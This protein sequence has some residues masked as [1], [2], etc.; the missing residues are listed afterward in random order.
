[1]VFKKVY[2]EPTRNDNIMDCFIK[3]IFESAGKDFSSDKLVHLQFQKFSRG[4]FKD[5]AIIIYSKSKDKYTISTTYEYANE[6]V[7]AVAEKLGNKKILVSG[8]VVSTMDLG[9]E[10]EFKNIKQYMGVKQYIFEKELSGNE[11][12]ELCNKFP[13]IFLGFSFKL[14]DE[15]TEIKIKPKAPKSAKP[16]VKYSEEQK[17]KANF[18]KLTT[19]DKN[20]VRSFVFDNEIDI[21]KVK[22]AEISHDFI[23]SEII[24]PKG[25]T[26]FARMRELAKRKGKIIRR[27]NIDGKTIK[28][29]AEF[30]A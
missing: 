17:I 28:K 29:E 30:I 18:C 16:S 10:I 20:L 19:S 12:L 14:P 13:T 24:L 11:I 4:E 22:R 26:D 23:V 27:L 6:F 21:D 3:K 25:E 8:V 2:K 5:K 9:S 15:N 1:M 7:R